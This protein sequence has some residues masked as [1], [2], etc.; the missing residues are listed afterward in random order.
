MDGYKGY[1]LR[2]RGSVDKVL[3]SPLGEDIAV[4]KYAFGRSVPLV[5]VLAPEVKPR[6]DYKG[7]TEIVK[8][9]ADQHRRA[10]GEDQEDPTHSEGR[11]ANVFNAPVQNVQV[12]QDAARGAQTSGDQLNAPREKPAPPRWR[13]WIAQSAV[14]SAVAAVLKA[15]GLP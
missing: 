7:V 15:I 6:G 14:G 13:D 4:L 5:A 12:N 2:P 3:V 8:D 11:S 10:V 9:L 1:V